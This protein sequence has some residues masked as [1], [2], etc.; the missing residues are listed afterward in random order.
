MLYPFTSLLAEFGGSLGLFLGVSFIT[1]SDGVEGLV[2]WLKKN[3][4]FSYQVE[5]R[6]KEDFHS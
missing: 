6:V 1:I 4:R 3:I 5:Y 2:V